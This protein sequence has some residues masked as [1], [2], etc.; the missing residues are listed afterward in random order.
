MLAKPS[1]GWTYVTI[2]DFTGPASYLTDVPMD[3]MSHM[4]DAL[5]DGR[6]FCA[7]FDAEGWSYKVISDEYWTAVIEEKNGPVLHTIDGVNKFDLAKELIAD[8]KENLDAWADW[9]MDD[10]AE[11]E[12]VHDGDAADFEEWLHSD[13]SNFGTGRKWEL[14]ASLKYLESLFAEHEQQVSGKPEHRA[15]G[16]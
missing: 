15:M 10:K 9:F 11:E 6:D 8:V 13:R 16:S 12:P 1:C 7:S 3:C 5:E 2:G 4:I 14:D